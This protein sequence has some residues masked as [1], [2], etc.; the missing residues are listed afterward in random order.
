MIAELQTCVAYHTQCPAG[1]TQ[2]TS[3][4]H[5]VHGTESLTTQQ[6]ENAS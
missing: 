3:A 6:V 1:V 2:L 4:Q 5:I